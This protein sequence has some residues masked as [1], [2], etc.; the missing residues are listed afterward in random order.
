MSDWSLEVTIV[1]KEDGEKLSKTLHEIYKLDNATADMGADSIL[2][3]IVDQIH[4]WQEA[5]KSGSANFGENPN[6]LIKSR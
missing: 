3:K 2:M 1:V 4:E 5:K 6:G